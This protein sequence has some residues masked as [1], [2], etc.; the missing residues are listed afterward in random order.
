MSRDK[1]KKGADVKRGR[2]KILAPRMDTVRSVG[3]DEPA[4][5][6]DQEQERRPDEK[7]ADSRGNPRDQACTH[8]SNS[9]DLFKLIE[10]AISRDDLVL[11]DQ[12]LE[13]LD[14]IL[15]HVRHSS[16]VYDEWGFGA[17]NSVGRGI[18]VLFVG[19]S[20]TGRKLAAEM[21]AGELQRDLFQIDLSLVV[22]KSSSE[23]RK[24]L[25]RIFD[26]CQENSAVLMFDDVDPFFG[27][28]SEDKSS[29]DR[30]SSFV[31]GYLLQR[32]EAYD[33]LAIVAA[34][35]RKFL[36]DVFMRRLRFVLSFPLPDIIQR[37]EIWRKVFPPPT[38][39]ADLDIQELAQLELSG[40]HIR[41]VAL[42][43]AFL[44]AEQ[45]QP[46]GMTHLRRAAE[47]IFT[48]L[49]MPIISAE[50]STWQ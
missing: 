16:K 9:L 49:D 40:G 24:N 42:Y 41:E 32:M 30:N 7:P 43:A 14:D 46:V 6:R 37:E 48:K 18:S 22:S 44:A 47:A 34:A 2:G 28:R 38:P 15:V 4:Q 10:P 29:T 35:R 21:L 17:K 39:T 45:N 25:G 5:G 3:P 33:G 1:S 36:D 8:R 20:G 50:F 26:V 12:I 11:P 23:T 13:S 27:R 31:A 19:P